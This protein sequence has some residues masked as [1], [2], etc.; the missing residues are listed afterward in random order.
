M[1]GY[2]KLFGSILASTIWREDKNTRIV[3]I[4]MLAMANRNGLVEGSIPGVADM[5]RLSVDETREAIVKLESPDPDSRSKDQEG[6]RIVPVDGGWFLVNHAKYRGKM[7]KDD[8]REYMKTYMRAKRSAVNSGVS[9]SKLQLAE[10]THTDQIQIRSDTEEVQQ[11]LVLAEIPK[12]LNW[13]AFTS[14]WNKWM[15][16]R[17]GLRKVKD[18]NQLFSAQLDW[19]K[20]FGPVNATEIITRAI[21]NGW[22]GLH[23]RNEYDATNRKSSSQ[24]TDRNQGTANAG[25]AN[26]Y[27]GMGKLGQV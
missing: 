25:K 16:Y 14:A 26:Q 20:G 4:T 24:S 15:D 2:T 21:R 3:W 9:K 6:R 12:E 27:A 22:T 19:L 5:A 10:L 11:A 7:S 17:R 18:W 8:R 13:P 23:E 1:H